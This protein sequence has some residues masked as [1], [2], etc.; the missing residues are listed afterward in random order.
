MTGRDERTVNSD[1]VLYYDPYENFFEQSPDIDSAPSTL[2][3]TEF[4]ELWSGRAEERW[5]L[6]IDRSE[7]PTLETFK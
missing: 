2:S 6:W 4:F 5:T 7:Q 1:S 3:K